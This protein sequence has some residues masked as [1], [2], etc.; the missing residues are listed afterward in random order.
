[1]TA[2]STRHSRAPTGDQHGLSLAHRSRQGAHRLDTLPASNTFKVRQGQKHMFI[3]CCIICSLTRHA[4]VKCQ[5]R[6]AVL[7]TLN[8]ERYLS[9]SARSENLCLSCR[10]VTAVSQSH[11]IN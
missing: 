2:P 8:C 10:G 7:Q 9:A 11:S 6:L 3:L 1:M 4:L 5:A